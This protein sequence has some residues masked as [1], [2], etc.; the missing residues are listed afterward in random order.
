MV[1]SVD[2]SLYFT[3]IEVAFEV[4]KKQFT[5]IPL[6]HRF[7]CC[8]V[9]CDFHYKS[10]ILCILQALESSSTWIIEFQGEEKAAWLRGLVQ[11]T[12]QASVY[13]HNLFDFFFSGLFYLHWLCLVDAEECCPFVGSSVGGCTWSYK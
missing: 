1:E 11:A 5:D 9:I 8:I 13:L 10:R 6:Q 3:F 4:R 7:V 12:Y 2:D